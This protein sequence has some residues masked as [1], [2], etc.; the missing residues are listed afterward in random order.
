[1]KW[2]GKAIGAGLG[3]LFGGPFGAIL[4]TMTGDFFDKS[5][6]QTP[7][8]MP[9]SNQEKSLNFIT[10]LVGILVSIAKADGRVSTQEINVIERAFVSFGFQGEDLSFIRNLINQT[11]RVDLDLRAVSYE[12]KQYSS[13]EERLS[14]LRIVYLVAF[15]DKVLHPNEERMINDI[16]SFVEINAD[17]AFEI[18]A[19][20]CS[21]NDKHYRILNV[22]RNSSME[23]IKKSYRHLSKQYHPD[24]VSHLGDEFTRLASDKFQIINNAYEEIKKEKGF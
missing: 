21:D 11:S 15:A 22:T 4:G 18:R 5:L 1:M 14:L 23:D 7:I 2:K 10:H 3:F 6:K 16:I 20:F 17:D 19:E 8:G 12:F 24:R 13:Y 9:S